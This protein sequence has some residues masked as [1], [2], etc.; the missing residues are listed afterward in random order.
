[1]AWRNAGQKNGCSCKS[2]VWEMLS[3]FMYSM[4]LKRE[5]L[6]A[7]L[8]AENMAMSCLHLAE[9]ELKNAKVEFD[10]LNN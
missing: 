9:L 1:M 2:T 4:H 8:K 3:F 10:S 6:V 7:N 5:E